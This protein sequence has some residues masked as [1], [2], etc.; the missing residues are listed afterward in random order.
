[1][2]R[3]EAAV[4]SSKADYN[5]WMFYK[6][7]Q[8]A[9]INKKSKET[10]FLAMAALMEMRKIG[11]TLCPECSGRGHHAKMCPTRRKLTRLGNINNIARGVV[12]VARKGVQN[13]YGDKIARDTIPN[14][15][16]WVSGKKRIYKHKRKM[17]ARF[18]RPKTSDEEEE[19]DE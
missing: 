10:E 6:F 8:E 13:F 2:K 1:M 18:K 7:A 19:E 11:K 4:H 14:Q 9:P 16:S 5:G 15:F 17:A 3:A 12:S